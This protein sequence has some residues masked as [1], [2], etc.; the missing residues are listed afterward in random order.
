[1][2]NLCLE[3]LKNLSLTIFILGISLM[4]SSSLVPKNKDFLKMYQFCAEDFDNIP[5][6]DQ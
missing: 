2:K 1:M 5:E 6:I 3:V 4:N